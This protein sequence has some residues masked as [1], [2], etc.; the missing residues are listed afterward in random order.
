M[1][2]FQDWMMQAEDGARMNIAG[3]RSK[4]LTVLLG[5]EWIIITR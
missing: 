3:H 1:R 2:F 5:G 4:V